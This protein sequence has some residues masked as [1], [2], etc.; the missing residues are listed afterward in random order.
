MAALLRGEAGIVTESNHGPERGRHPASRV[1]LGTQM[2]GWEDGGIAG[3]YVL[4]LIG[5]FSTRI[6]N[7]ESHREG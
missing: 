2:K 3:G 6:S 1:Q 5:N 7:C 4:S